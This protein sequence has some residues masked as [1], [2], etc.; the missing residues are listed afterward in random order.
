MSPTLIGIDELKSRSASTN[1]SDA[2]EVDV[3]SIV[4]AASDTDV[5]DIYRL[6]STHM[7]E[8]RLLPRSREEIAARVGRFIVA[9]SDAPIWRLSADGLRKCDRWSWLAAHVR[10]GPAVASC[11]NSRSARSCRVL[12]R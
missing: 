6:V 5:D 4:R 7:T 1:V 2:H 11:G 12:N 10:A 9:R 8:G 3:E